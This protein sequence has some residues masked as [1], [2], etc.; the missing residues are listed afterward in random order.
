M[1]KASDNPFPSV[2]LVEQA[3]KPAAPDSGNQR[4]YLKTDHKLYT[5]NSAE[6]ETPIGGT[7]TA[8]VHVD[9]AGEIAGVDEKV[10][11]VAADMILIEDSDDTN[12]KKMIQIGNLPG[13]VGGTNDIIVLRDERTEGTA[14][15]TFTSGAWQTR[16]LNTET[17]DSGNHCTLSSNQFTLD[18]GT[19]D[20]WSICPAYNVQ[21]H[22]SRLQNI[23]DAATI[24]LSSNIYGYVSGGSFGS[25]SL[26][27]GRF[28]IAASKALEL[29]HRSQSTEATD[30]FGNPLHLGVIEV[31]A[32]ITL[33]K[34]G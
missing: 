11:P 4:L 24:W 31:Y 10:T 27:S 29:Q 21:G 8:A 12:N 34:V 15:G 23:T 20:F 22:R 3:A 30:G 7:D 32:Q 28:T 16:I 26:M 6:T 33:W 13:G 19:Y 14:G 5:E 18:A 1:A 17:L 9:V 2:L 25:Y